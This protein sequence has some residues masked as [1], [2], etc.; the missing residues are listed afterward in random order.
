MGNTTNNLTFRQ[1]LSSVLRDNT[2][3]PATEE[4]LTL[5]ASAGTKKERKILAQRFKLK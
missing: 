4:M 1:Y 2:R 5:N 3:Y